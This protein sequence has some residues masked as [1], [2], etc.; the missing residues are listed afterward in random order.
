LTVSGPGKGG[1]IYNSAGVLEIY[2]T[3]V[4]SNVAEGGIGTLAPWASYG[5]DGSGG[6][7][8]NLGYLAVVNSTLANNLARGGD[9]TISTSGEAWGGAGFGGGLYCAENE[10]VL[11]NVTVQTILPK[12]ASYESHRSWE[13]RFTQKL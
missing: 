12:P 1:A 4:V 9:G 8:Y 5:G 2:E 10:I 3:A 7:V 13:A 11:L 6:G